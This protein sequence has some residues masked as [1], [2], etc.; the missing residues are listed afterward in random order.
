MLIGNS[1]SC[2]A[3]RHRLLVAPPLLPTRGETLFAAAPVSMR[4]GSPALSLLP[5]PGLARHQQFH[6]EALLAVVPGAVLTVDDLAAVVLDPGGRARPPALPRGRGVQGRAGE[7]DFLAVE[8]VL[9]LAE[10]HPRR[11]RVSPDAGEQPRPGLEA[12]QARPRRLR[13]AGPE[14]EVR[15]EEAAA[16]DHRLRAG[17]L[18]AVGLARARVERLD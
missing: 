17:P 9:A 1:P 16:V 4:A 5:R 11:A 6:G 18:G 12:D 15:A 3:F 7:A 14:D 13:V 8:L 2:D 10:R